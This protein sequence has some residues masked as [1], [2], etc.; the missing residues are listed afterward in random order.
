MAS[1]T[2]VT[3]LV[4]LILFSHQTSAGSLWSLRVLPISPCKELEFCCPDSTSLALQFITGHRVLLGVVTSLWTRRMCA[5]CPPVFTPSH[6][7]S[8]HVH[9]GFSFA[10]K[11]SL[12][13]NFT[14]CCPLIV[15]YRPC[16]ASDLNTTLFVHSQWRAT[17]ARDCKVF[18]A[19]LEI[20][21]F[22]VHIMIQL[23][24]ESQGFFEQ[25]LYNSRHHE[26][27]HEA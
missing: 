8:L 13:H 16:A 2:I 3:R 19:Q 11:V 18:L 10:I 7:Y 9:I 22:D 17:C 15:S 27:L 5:A 12:H 4:T 14:H 26:Q 24:F 23:Q 21:R 25:K 20:N 1:L 6:P